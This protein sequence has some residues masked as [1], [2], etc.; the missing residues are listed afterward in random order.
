[1]P[2]N[3]VKIKV[4]SSIGDRLVIVRVFIVALIISAHQLTGKACRCIDV[5]GQNPANR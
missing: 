4:E 2:A 3:S 1:M 5:S